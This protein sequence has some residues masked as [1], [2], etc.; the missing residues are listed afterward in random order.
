MEVKQRLGIP[1]AKKEIGTNAVAVNTSFCTDIPVMA[2]ECLDPAATTDTL[3]YS[4]KERSRGYADPISITSST[5]FSLPEGGVGL[6]A[7]LDFG[8]THIH[9]RSIL[10]MRGQIVRVIRDYPAVAPLPYPIPRTHPGVC[11]A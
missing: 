11:L 7:A 10:E 3:L 5:S 9:I 6:S 2:S 4:N 8:G 1:I